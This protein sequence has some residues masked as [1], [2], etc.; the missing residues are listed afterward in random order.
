VWFASNSVAVSDAESTSGFRGLFSENVN[1]D[2]H[3]ASVR[4]SIAGVGASRYYLSLSMLMALEKTGLYIQVQSYLK[5][6]LDTGA[7]NDQREDAGT[8]RQD[9]RI[10]ATRSGAVG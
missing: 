8:T 7:Y 9:S 3:R 2:T 6:V 1:G 5:G 4:Q 10:L